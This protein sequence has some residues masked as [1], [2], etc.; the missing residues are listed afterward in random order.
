MLFIRA[1]DG[2]DGYFKEDCESFEQED[3]EREV[4]YSLFIN[5][6]EGKFKLGIQYAKSIGVFEYPLYSS[7]FHAK[8]HTNE[9]HEQLIEDNHIF[10]P[11]TLYA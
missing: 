7:V 8:D 3:E 1:S 4:T 11:K 5:H 2:E 6:A 10:S 9:I